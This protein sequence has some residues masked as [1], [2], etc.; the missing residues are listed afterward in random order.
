[1]VYT[2]LHR[3]AQ[4]ADIAGTVRPSKPVVMFDE[5]E[6]KLAVKRTDKVYKN[7]KEL[8]KFPWTLLKVV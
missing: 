6:P 7:C 3:E 8:K 4:M 2:G 1:M 5:S